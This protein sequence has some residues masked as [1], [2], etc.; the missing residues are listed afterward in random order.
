M[1]GYSTEFYKEKKHFIDSTTE[2]I[3][4]GKKW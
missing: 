1:N 3:K 2:H 4:K